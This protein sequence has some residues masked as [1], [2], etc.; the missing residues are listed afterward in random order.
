VSRCGVPPEDEGAVLLG[1]AEQLREAR[2]E[3]E[4]LKAALVSRQMIGVAQGMLMLRYGLSLDRTFEYLS[5]RSQDENIKLRVVAET[6]IDELTAEGW[7][8]R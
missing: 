1:M 2:D 4:Q 5:R 6:V 3:V 8:E 7:P